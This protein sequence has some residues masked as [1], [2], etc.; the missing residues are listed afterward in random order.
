M[1]LGM[2]KHRVGETLD[3]GELRQFAAAGAT[4]NRAAQFLGVHWSTVERVARA[5]RIAFPSH[6]RG[7]GWRGVDRSR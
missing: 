6:A 7:Y 2:V 5:H 1:R 4:M 3:P